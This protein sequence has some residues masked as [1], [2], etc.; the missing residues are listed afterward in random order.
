MISAGY[1]ISSMIT[2]LEVSSIAECTLHESEQHRPKE[3]VGSIHL[4]GFRS[5]RQ[6]GI[7]QTSTSSIRI[8]IQYIMMVCIC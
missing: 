8:H 1:S 5:S 3:G 6:H 7:L 2:F 4:T